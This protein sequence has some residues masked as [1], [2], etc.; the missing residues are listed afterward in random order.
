MKITILTSGHKEYQGFNTCLNVGRAF[1]GRGHEVTAILRHL[2]SPVRVNRYARDG[3]RFIETPMPLAYTW[4]AGDWGLLSLLHRLGH[5]GIRRPDAVLYW[6]A[7]PDVAVPF[8]FSRLIRGVKVQISIWADVLSGDGLLR[9]RAGTRR[10]W[11]IPVNSFFE[12]S[13]KRLSDGVIPFTDVLYDRAREWGI[14]EDRLL[15]GRFGADESIITPADRAT[16]KDAL[17]IPAGSPVLGFMGFGPSQELIH[18]LM[19]PFQAV[20]RRFPNAHLL[21]I[22]PKDAWYKGNEEFVSHLRQIQN[23]PYGKLSG[24]LSAADILLLPFPPGSTGNEGR[25]PG[26]M[27]EYLATGRPTVTCDV[28]EMSRLFRAEEIGLLSKPDM[29]DFADRIMDLLDDPERAERMGRRA[30][31]LAETTYSWSGFIQRTETFIRD[32]A[33]RKGLELSD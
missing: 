12:R 22:C 20:L 8:Y 33:A 32:L 9:P 11:T 27:G 3:V 5:F 2:G 10:A 15:R 17:G 7:M 25:W 28:G 30:R 16:A 6:E 23:L 26:K 29:S 21:L 13:L 18:G 19:D 1:A 31:R 24:V 14:R 4:H